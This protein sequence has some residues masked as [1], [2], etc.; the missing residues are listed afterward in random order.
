MG[1]LGL[2]AGRARRFALLG[3]SFFFVAAGVNHFLD[4][5]FYVR[6]MPP[7]LPAH[8]FLVVVSGVF[9]IGG[10]LAVL[11]PGWRGRAGW[12]LAAL[13]V[14]VFPA[15]VYMAMNPHLFLD[16]PAA[17]LLGR[18]PLQVLFI[19]WAIWATRPD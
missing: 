1:P 15:N 8:R 9:E 12:F 10:G 3:L 19:A 5:G 13:L 17:A 6:M 11:L 2:P 18:L 4:P 16:I 7:A 14:A